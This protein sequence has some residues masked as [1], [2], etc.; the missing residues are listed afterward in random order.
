M[1][2][3][4]CHQQFPL[5]ETG[6][7]IALN[8]ALKRLIHLGLEWEHQFGELTYNSR[9]KHSRTESDSRRRQLGNL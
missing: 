6:M 2:A 5:G 9:D 7:K 3:V 4:Q 8:S 1:N